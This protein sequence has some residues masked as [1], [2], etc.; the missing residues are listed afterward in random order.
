MKSEQCLVTEQCLVCGKMKENRGIA[1]INEGKAI[2]KGFNHLRLKPFILIY[3]TI[4]CA[5]TQLLHL[6]IVSLLDTVIV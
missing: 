2:K 1:V 5:F 6:V 4:Q 3:Q